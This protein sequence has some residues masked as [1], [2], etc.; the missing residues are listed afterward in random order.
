MKNTDDNYGKIRNEGDF[1]RPADKI[2]TGDIMKNFKL[3]STR[4]L[5][6]AF[7]FFMLMNLLINN[8]PLGLSRMLEIT[9]GNTILDMKM[10]GYTVEEAYRML[11]ALGDEGRR[12]YLTRIAPLDIPFPLSYGLFYFVL[13]SLIA[14]YLFKNFK[15]PW[16]I[17]LL[18]F[19]PTLFDL[20]EN[21]MVLILL[22]SYPERVSSAASAASLFTRVKALTMMLSLSA[23]TAGLIAT[24]IVMISRRLRS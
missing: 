10:S 8:S 9:G 24:A 22:L 23:I 5:L 4:G 19:V 15:K 3:I 12:F 20:L 1:S 6:A 18:G 7:L 14:A 11:D 16:I 13:L 21:S 17:G 2:Q